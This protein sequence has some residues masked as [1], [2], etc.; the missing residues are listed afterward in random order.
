MRTNHFA[1]C[2]R[3]MRVFFFTLIELLVVI[4][5]IAIL[6]S[7]L[8]PSLNHAKGAA[9]ASICQ[10]NMKQFGIL[11]SSYTND[12][13]DF[14]PMN[15][16]DGTGY[17][18]GS[19]YA[20]YEYLGH[21]PQRKSYAGLKQPAIYKCPA[22][23]V[24][25][26]SNFPALSYGINDRLYYPSQG[27][28]LKTSKFLS[29]GQIIMYGEKF[30]QYSYYWSEPRLIWTYDVRYFWQYFTGKTYDSVILSRDIHQNKQ[31]YS[32]FDGHAEKLDYWST[33]MPSSAANG[34]NTFTIDARWGD[35]QA[36]GSAQSMVKKR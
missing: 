1:V 19:F 28:W 36:T 4:A 25:R 10:G 18:W 33:I 23:D 30:I 17:A 5:I 27:K 29:P 32:F 31:M 14:Y 24:P 9:K 34:S 26:D 7:L 13:D 16:N 20:F 6:A 22:D 11:Q 3:S 8:L 2:R 15:W 35:K 12:Y 21:S